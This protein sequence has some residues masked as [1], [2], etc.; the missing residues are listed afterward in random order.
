MTKA[1][2]FVV[3]RLAEPSTYKGAILALT[4]LGCYVRPEIAAA[5]TSIG[6]GV[7][8]LIGVFAADPAAPPASA[9]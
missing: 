5:I 1:F 8:G 7:A 3:A 2:H 6:L 4:G 9:E